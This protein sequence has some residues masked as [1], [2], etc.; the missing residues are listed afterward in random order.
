MAFGLGFCLLAYFYFILFYFS[1]SFMIIIHFLLLPLY[2][3]FIN[4]F[5]YLLFIF[6]YLFIYFLLFPN[7][8][9]CLSIH[10][11]YL[12]SRISCFC[13]ETYHWSLRK[14]GLSLGGFGGEFEIGRIAFDWNI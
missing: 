11:I 7:L 6:V 9:T 4:L 14:V 3:I 10:S 2:I 12:T 1:F 5:I 13:K 8:F